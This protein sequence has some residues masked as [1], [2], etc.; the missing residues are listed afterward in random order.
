MPVLNSISRMLKEM[1]ELIE[2]RNTKG[3]D[4]M[5]KKFDQLSKVAEKK[6]K[7]IYNQKFI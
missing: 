5:L 6:Q 4:A 2:L 3:K 1:K 7:I